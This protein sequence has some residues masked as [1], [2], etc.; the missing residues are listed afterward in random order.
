MKKH[1]GLTCES[2][3]YIAK[4]TINNKTSHYLKMIKK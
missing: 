1:S 3:I 4:I 2:G